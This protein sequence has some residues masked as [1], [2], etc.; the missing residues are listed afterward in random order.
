[1]YIII[2]IK[3]CLVTYITVWPR[4][5]ALFMTSPSQTNG[6]TEMVVLTV[7]FSR[8]S[9]YEKQDEQSRYV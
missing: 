8:T 9:V 2:I 7:E 5:S 3:C 1:M 4:G 6:H